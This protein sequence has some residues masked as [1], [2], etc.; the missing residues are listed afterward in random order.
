MDSARHHG[1]AEQCDTW[2]LKDELADLLH[3]NHADTCHCTHSNPPGTF[4]L[5]LRQATHNESAGHECARKPRNYYQEATL[6]SE[7]E[8]VVMCLVRVNTRIGLR[9]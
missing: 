9:M 3:R 8:I 4:V 5:R 1:R 6:D 2:N 7:L